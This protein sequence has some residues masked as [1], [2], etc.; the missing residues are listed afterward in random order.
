MKTPV[1]PDY[2][3]ISCAYAEMK[4]C[5]VHNIENKD[6]LYFWLADLRQESET[7]AQRAPA[8]NVFFAN[9]PGRP[10]C[11][12]FLLIKLQAFTCNFIK[13][14]LQLKYIPVNFAKFLKTAILKDTCKHILQ[15]TTWVQKKNCKTL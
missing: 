14:R 1:F 4:F 11:Q 5:A 13:K 10:M 12:S 9:F 2:L 8:K 15:E 7:V 3:A 6:F